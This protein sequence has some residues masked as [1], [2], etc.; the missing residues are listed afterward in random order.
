[1]KLTNKDWKKIKNNI[2]YGVIL[3]IIGIIIAGILFYSFL[4]YVS[5][6]IG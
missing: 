6:Y 2:I 3:Y 4:K 1:M 5:I